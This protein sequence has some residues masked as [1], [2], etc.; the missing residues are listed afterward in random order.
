MNFTERIMKGFIL[1]AKCIDFFRQLGKAVGVGWWV[2]IHRGGMIHMCTRFFGRWT[3]GKLE[4][5]FGRLLTKFDFEEWKFCEEYEEMKN[6]AKT[7]MKN[8]MK[9]E[10]TK[11]ERMKNE[12][13]VR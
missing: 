7:E 6:E 1:S 10:R 3:G 9:N 2:G 5:S 4:L 11:N 8:K 13:N 12:G